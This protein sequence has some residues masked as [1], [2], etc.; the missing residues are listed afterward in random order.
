MMKKLH[1]FST[2]IAFVLA[3]TTVYSAERALIGSSNIAVKLDYIAF[4]DKQWNGQGDDGLYI[5]LEGYGEISPNI[6]LGG[7]IGNGVNMD[8]LGDDLNLITI[9]LNGKYAIK[10]A[11]NAAIDFGAG[12]SY[13]NADIRI[14]QLFSPDIEDKEWLF[15]GQI[16]ADLDYK[17]KKFIIGINGK[18]QITANFKG[19]NFNLS[20]L[21]LGIQIGM[22]F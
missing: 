3:F 13:N 17:I 5:G 21:R 10:A 2:I 20:N 9:E 4:T 7:E 1:L 11:T 15:G 12:V 14:D 19:H 6:Y 22:M 16:F 8:I 18:Y